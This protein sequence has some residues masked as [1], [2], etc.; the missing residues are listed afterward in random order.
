MMSGSFTIRREKC[1]A[2]YTARGIRPSAKACTQKC[3]PALFPVWGC[4]ALC[5]SLAMLGAHA[6]RV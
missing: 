6:L 2:P 5:V 1:S 3:V 4:E